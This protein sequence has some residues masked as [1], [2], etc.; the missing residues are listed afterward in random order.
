MSQSIH[1]VYKTPSELPE[2]IPAEACSDC[3]LAVK[4][5]L[6]F[7]HLGHCFCIIP[8]LAQSPMLQACCSP[9]SSLPR[10]P[11]PPAPTRAVPHSSRCTPTGLHNEQQPQQP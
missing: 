6:I 4:V 3:H 5:F 2:G 7:L 10:R 9:Q 11:T 1:R 8:D